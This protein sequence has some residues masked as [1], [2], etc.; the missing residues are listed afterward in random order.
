MDKVTFIEK[1]ASR[2]HELGLT[3]PAVL[4]L[5][6]HKPLTFISSQLLLIVQP[7]LDIILPGDFTG[8]L[9]NL[10]ADPDQ[11]EQ[12][13]TNLE[14]KAATPSLSPAIPPRQETDL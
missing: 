5:E 13:I 1:V 12:L 6:A 8:S 4:L 11:F 14:G 2:I 10:L 9:V 7:T 3:V